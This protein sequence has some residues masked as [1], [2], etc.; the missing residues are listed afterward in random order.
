MRSFTILI[1][2]LLSSIC[3][4][5][6]QNQKA[7]ATI[8][9]NPISAGEFIYAFKKNRPKNEKITV[10]SLDKYLEQYINFKLKVLAAEQQGIDTT[11]LFIDEYEGYISQ[12]Q[13]PYM[14]NPVS[15]IDIIQEAYDRMKYEINASHILIRITT[16]NNPLDTLKAFQK[17]DSIRD[18]AVKGQAFEELAKQFSADGSSQKG[19]SLG[20]FGAMAMVYPFE[21]GA[22]TTNV[23]EISKIVR[24]QFGYH[25]IKVNDRREAKGKIKTSHIF[26][27]KSGRPLESG[28]KLI[29]TIYDSIQAGNNWKEVCQ[30]YSE[31]SG[32]NSNGGSLPL[33][34]IGE[35]P[36]EFLNPAFEIKNIGEVR[37]PI[38]TSYGWHIIRLDAKQTIPSFDSMK[39]QISDQV[40]RS[41]R[42]QLDPD[43]LLKKLKEENG[44]TQDFQLLNTTIDKAASTG[45]ANLDLSQLGLEEI[46]KIGAL[47]VTYNH[48]FS[49]IGNANQMNKSAL[50]SRYKSF[51]RDQILK[52]EEKVAEFKYP[53]YGYLLKEY[54]EGL[55]LF[56]IM[57]KEVWQKSSEDS[58]GLS[59]YYE[60][61]INRYPAPERADFTV[62]ETKSLALFTKINDS[63]QF[64]WSEGLKNQLS[65]QLKPQDFAALKIAKRTLERFEIANFEGNWTEKSLITDQAELKIYALESI[66][67]AGNY[68]LDEVK[69]IVI[70][71]YQD[72]LDGRWVKTLRSENKIRI[73]KK[74]LRQL[75]SYEND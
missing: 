69:G 48:F 22:Y 51:E 13:K 12:V 56:E 72:H 49:E 37:Q 67:K 52:Y 28:R 7:I 18:L 70:S 6:F 54:K 60:S 68:R 64:K 74:A 1:S 34:G 29:R 16:A 44:F 21:T 5:G 59:Q 19:G 62:I 55:M 23:G 50:W 53:E 9:G 30:Q 65:R 8:N 35:L 25:I 71:D 17:T 20:W 38:E 10:D 11:K 24:S 58:L 40:K 39:A 46:F 41:G 47:A 4:F 2:L 26:L 3:L 32:T 42:N 27:T 31:D 45:L 73:D 75:A 63:I 15:E 36:D 14:L 61:H 66:I 43:E 33:A 57:E